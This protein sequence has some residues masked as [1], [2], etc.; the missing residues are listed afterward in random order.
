MSVKSKIKHKMKN[1]PV[2]CLL[3]MYHEALD[4][5][6]ISKDTAGPVGGTQPWGLVSEKSGSVDRTQLTGTCQRSFEVRDV[7]VR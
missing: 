1:S 7:S 5:P 6:G 4:R 2:S 3:R